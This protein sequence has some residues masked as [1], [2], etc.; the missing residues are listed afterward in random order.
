MKD[1]VSVVQFGTDYCTS[2]GFCYILSE[3]WPNVTERAQV[4]EGSTTYCID[5]IMKS[6]LL[7]ECCSKNFNFF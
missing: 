7:I 5:M 3:S 2:K 4:I 1:G 6:E